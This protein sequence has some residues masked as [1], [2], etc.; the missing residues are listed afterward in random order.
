MKMGG[1]KT[2]S[3]FRRYAIVSD[4]DQRAAVQALERAR[5][6][7]NSAAFGPAEVKAAPAATQPTLAKPQ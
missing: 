1:W 7:Q 5:A 3:M 4:A 2:A 6:E